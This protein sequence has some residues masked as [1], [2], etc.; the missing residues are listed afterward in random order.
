MLKLGY[1]D[2]YC[3]GEP[4]TSLAVHAG[5]GMCEARRALDIAQAHEL[6]L[7]EAY[8][9][10]GAASVLSRDPSSTEW[11]DASIAAARAEND[12]PVE[13]TSADTLWVALLLAGDA[14]RCLALAEEMID[15]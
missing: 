8:G 2:G 1:L 6:P 12:F 15:R 4:W 3:S 5:A 10:L 14:T 9:A 13:A 11:L 7:A